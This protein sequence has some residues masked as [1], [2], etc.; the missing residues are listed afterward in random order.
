MIIGWAPVRGTSCPG[1]MRLFIVKGALSSDS[2]DGASDG[3]CSEE[4]RVLCRHGYQKTAAPIERCALDFTY[5][6]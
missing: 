4:V 2:G 5:R 3:P 1:R 6:G